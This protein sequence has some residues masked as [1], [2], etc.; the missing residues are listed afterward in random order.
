MDDW[1]DVFDSS[2]LRLRTGALAATLAAMMTLPTEKRRDRNLVTGLTTA[3]VPRSQ[4]STHV[5][6]L[7]IVRRP[8]AKEGVG[9]VQPTWR[10]NFYEGRKPGPGQAVETRRA[11]VPVRPTKFGATAAIRAV[12]SVHLS[13]SEALQNVVEITLSRSVML[14][15][16]AK[17]ISVFLSQYMHRGFTPHSTWKYYHTD[18]CRINNSCS[19]ECMCSSLLKH[20]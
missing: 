1:F 19:A 14:S 8:V 15:A 20:T 3:M 17:E 2:L 7:D 12:I 10:R 9:V 6:R 4:D 5:P 13:W 16:Q 18:I 11:L